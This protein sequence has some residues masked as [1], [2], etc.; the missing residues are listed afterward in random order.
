MFE[1]VGG[2]MY[3]F[4]LF[5]V[6]YLPPHNKPSPTAIISQQFGDT[7]GGVSL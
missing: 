4:T 1:F 3:T 5:V 2:L 7:C 6:F